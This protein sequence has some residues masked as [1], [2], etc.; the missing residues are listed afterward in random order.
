MYG[1]R[2]LK[3]AIQRELET[4]IAKAIQ[5]GTFPAGST[6]A[7]EVEAQGVSDDNLVEGAS[8]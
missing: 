3:C 1:A 6:I 2:P 5:A 4:P 7:V 8:T